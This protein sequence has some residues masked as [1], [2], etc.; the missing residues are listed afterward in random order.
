MKRVVAVACCPLLCGCSLRLSVVCGIGIFVF[1]FQSYGI[2]LEQNV[3]RCQ[4][5][6][7]VGLRKAY[8]ALCVPVAKTGAGTTDECSV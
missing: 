5:S 4:N 8:V 2:D 1:Q 7:L 6:L 3:T